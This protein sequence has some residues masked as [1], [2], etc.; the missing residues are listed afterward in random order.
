MMLPQCMN[1]QK[2][3]Q[4]AQLAKLLED[5]QEDLPLNTRTATHRERKGIRGIIIVESRL[6]Q[7]VIGAYLFI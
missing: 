6:I 3:K 2:R 7:V 4:G 1:I 5:A